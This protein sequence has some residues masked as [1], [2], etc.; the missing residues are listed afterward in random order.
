MQFFRLG[1]SARKRALLHEYE[2]RALS[3]LLA[4]N[5]DN[6]G[7]SQV[8]RLLELTTGQKFDNLPPDNKIEMFEV[9]Y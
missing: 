4:S 9:G 6:I 5:L 3:G 1:G 2:S 7:H 8:R